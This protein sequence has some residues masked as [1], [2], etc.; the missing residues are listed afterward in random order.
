[1]RRRERESGVVAVEAAIV[2]PAF[3]FFILIFYSIIEMSMLQARMTI[4]L[5][6]AA[7]EISQYSYLYMLTGLNEKQAEGYQQGEEVRVS[8]DDTISGLQVLTDSFIPVSEG[9][10]G[11]A[12]NK[13]DFQTRV[14]DLEDKIKAAGG[15]TKEVSS[16]IYETWS[17]QLS[18]PKAFIAGVLSIAGNEIAEEAKAV[19]AGMLAKSFM[20]KNLKAGDLDDAESYLVSQHVKDGID[21]LDF[22]GTRLFANGKSERIQLVCSYDVEII[23]FFNISITPLHFQTTAITQAWGTGFSNPKGG[24]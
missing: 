11:L 8:V 3:M 18:D 4:A 23:K 7:K 21:G 15:T 14:T 12:Q 13:E 10:R 20:C 16:D 22:N 24:E 19:I 5:N 6:T 2:V 9:V 17:E 1:M